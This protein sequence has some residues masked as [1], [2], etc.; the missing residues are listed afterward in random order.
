MN[1]EIKCKFCKKK[2]KERKVFCN[3]DCQRK[4]YTIWK[5]GYNKGYKAGKKCKQ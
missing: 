5:D 2:F 3:R 1:K 4:Y